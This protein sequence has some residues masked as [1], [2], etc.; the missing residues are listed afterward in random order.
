MHA[1]ALREA[2]VVVSRC[3]RRCTSARCASGRTR[4]TCRTPSRKD[5][6]SVEP[7]SESRAGRSGVRRRSSRRA[8]RSPATTARWRRWFDYAL[9]RGDGA[10][11]SRLVV[12]A[13]RA[14]SRRQ[15]RAQQA[16]PAAERPLARPAAVRR[17][18]RLSAPVRRRDDPVRDQRH[19]ARDFAAEALRVLRRG[20]AGDQHADAGMRGVRRSA[21]RA[22]RGGSSRPRSTSRGRGPATRRSAH[23]C[24]RSP[25]A[26]TWR[27]R[28]RET[29]QRWSS[30]RRDQ[31]A[32]GARGRSCRRCRDPP[33]EAPREIMRR[34]AH[35]RPSTTVILFRA[36]VATSCRQS[37]TTLLCRLYFEFAMSANERGHKAAKADRGDRA[38]RR[39]ADARRRLCIR[40]LAGRARRARCR[41]DRLRH[42]RSRCLRSP[43]TTSSMPAGAIRACIWPTSQC[44]GRRAL[45]PHVRRDHVQRRHRAPPTRPC[46]GH[47]ASMLRRGGRRCT[48]RCR[49]R[50]TSATILA[51]GTSATREAHAIAARRARTAARALRRP[52]HGARSASRIRCAHPSADP[53]SMLGELVALRRSRPTARRD[54]DEAERCAD[55]DT[56]SDRMRFAVRYGMPTWTVV[57][58]PA[59]RTRALAAGRSAVSTSC[60]RAVLPHKRFLRGVCNIC[61]RTT[62]FFH[63]DPIARSRVADLPALSGDLALPIDRARRAR[64]DRGADRHPRR[65]RCR[66]ARWRPPASSFR[67]LRNATGVFHRGL[68]VSAAGYL[69]RCRWIDL[70]VSV[71]RPGLACGCGHRAGRVINHESRAA[72][73]SP[74]TCSTSSSPAT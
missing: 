14:G 41:T 19:H 56:P 50:T 54:L 61:G 16:R 36:L 25:R 6:S 53:R 29:M 51:S 55:R 23:G 64:G 9:L 72:D 24:T 38:A 67:A 11:A 3:A 34:F 37:R 44:R 32:G 69:Q 39:Q 31:R 12:R 70:T 71:Y 27:A 33:T 68:R 52:V 21:D 45:P 63:D 20:T 10:P 28:A 48:S 1:R 73:V 15:P 49:I 74:M 4:S 59:E 35:S 47:M 43:S 26:N 57:A 62:R 46:L 5:A 22:R 13:D 60:R 7:R 18:A 58:L 17:A 66:A 8:S 65:L 40:R 30:E 2:D 42:R